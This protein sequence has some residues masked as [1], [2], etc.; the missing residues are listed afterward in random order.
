MPSR[1]RQDP[2]VQEVPPLV[3]DVGGL[4]VRRLLPGR[5]RRLVGAWCFLDVFGPLRFEAGAKPMDVPP[6]PHIGLQTVTWLLDGESLHRDSLGSLA[7]ARPGTLNL[8]TSGRGIAHSEETPSPAPG[9]LH[10]VQLWVALPDACRHV[11]PWFD[12]HPDRPVAELDGGRARVIVGELAGVTGTARTFSPI[13]GAEVAVEAA[14][15]IVLPLEP[16]FEHSI[17]PL[18]AGAA[19]DG[20]PLSADTLYYLGRGRRELALENQGGGAPRL[21][22]LGGEPFAEAI[23]MWWNFVARTNDEIATA[24]DDW[25]AGR[26]FGE[27]RG[28]P[29]ERLPAPPF[30]AKPVPANPMS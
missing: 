9:R 27:V 13:V 1:R 21:L 2:T 23:R 22:L 7:T 20:R 30:T 12:H 19:L 5:T 15:R 11:E 18:E 3:T 25:Q 14:G 24:R 28:Y 4:A 26:R 10:G 17:V 16:A 8:M 6:H 29:G